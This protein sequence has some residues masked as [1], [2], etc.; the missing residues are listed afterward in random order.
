MQHNP[1]PLFLV[2][3]ATLLF[4]LVGPPS[5]YA[6]GVRA[7]VLFQTHC[8][9]CH[10]TPTPDSRAPNREEL[11]QR[12]P[13]AVLEAIAT[14]PMASMARDLTTEQKR[15]LA[16]Y[17]VGRR[18]GSSASGDASEMPN[19]CAATTMA[20]PTK[21]PRWNGW[22][23]DAG[24]TRFQPA[25]AA[26]L[27]A[28]QVPT[29]KLKWA[30]GFPNAGSMYGQPSVAGGRVYAGSDTGIVY[31]IDAATGCVYWSFRAQAGVRTAI[32][33]GAVEGSKPARYAAYFGDVKAGVYAVDTATGKLI[34]TRKADPHPIAR[35]T[36]APALYEGRLYVPVASLEELAGA[37]PT[38]ECC[39]FRGSIVAYDA[40]TGKELW[41]TY[42]IPDAPKPLKKTSKGT[43]LWG[44][45][46]AA[47]W[48]APTVDAKR[49]ML[50]FA[51]GDAYTAPA[52]DTSDAVMAIDIRTGRVAWTRQLES[53]DAWIVNCPADDKVKDRSENCPEV[54]EEGPDFDF[55]QSPML[56]S[57]RNGHD[58]IVIGQKSGIGWGLDPDAKGAVLWSHR[59][60]LGSTNG[61]MEW[62]S[63]TDGHLVYFPNA[64]NSWGAEKAGGLAAVEIETGERVWFT[65]PPPIPCANG[66]RDPKCVQAQSAAITVIP[67]V[68]FSG[69][70]NGIMRAYNADSGRII[71]EYNTQQDYEAVNGVP[72]HG[73]AI[74]GPGPTVVNG[75]VYM[76]SGY[77]ALG[78]GTPGNALLAFGVE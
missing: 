72:T 50:Y 8:A 59:V 32:T 15:T 40:A 6:Q 52:A 65:R 30:F 61:G 41:K 37:D 77:A 27:T 4:S 17:V 28:A 63:A 74:N 23:V 47:V 46:G 45:A 69:A 58:I 26:G 35:I 78:G 64:D 22:G 9:Q 71:W 66:N 68:V 34:W 7:I 29:L 60:G 13:E 31:S 44:Q 11:A 18:L 21:G 33:I 25:T 75:M 43:Q 10:G 48:N 62:G 36:G 14:G 67:G 57:L 73:G 54:A 39:T 56:H 12:T 49:G 2:S 38:Y 19:R 76:T 55:G 1:V 53:G 3:A 20:D 5:L 16:E 24:N 42:T 51:T 70:S